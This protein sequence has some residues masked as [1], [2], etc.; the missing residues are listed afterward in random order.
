M[1]GLVT[2]VAEGLVTPS[3]IT[4]IPAGLETPETIE[5]RK[6]KIESEMED[7]ETPALYTVLQERRTDGFGSSM[8]GSTHVYDMTGTGGQVPPTVIAA[9]R[10][11]VNTSEVRAKEKENAIELALDP[12]ELDLDSEAMA[13]RYEETMR[14]RK[15]MLYE[16]LSDMVKDHVQKQKVI[17]TIFLYIQLKA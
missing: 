15:A 6:R 1:T 16:N 10:G 5:L 14:N 12:S 13:S 9:R 17:N 8:M 11:N 4:S 2:P 3:G 7:G